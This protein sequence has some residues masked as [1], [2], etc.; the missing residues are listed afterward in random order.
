[1]VH[2]SSLAA[3]ALAMPLVAQAIQAEQQFAVLNKKKTTLDHAHK[4]L[5]HYPL[6]DTHNDLP[7]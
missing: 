6:I 5:S 7:M 2:W 1:M 3:L 4:L